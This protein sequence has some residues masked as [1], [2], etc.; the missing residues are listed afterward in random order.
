M[1]GC[2][3]ASGW[4]VPGHASL[5]TGRLAHDHGVHAF[6]PRYDALDPAE[7]LAGD[8]AGHTIGVS[9]N[10]YTRSDLGFDTLFDEF[11]GVT[12]D[13]PSQRGLD[14]HEAARGVEGVSR[15]PHLLKAALTHDSPGRSLANL[16]RVEAD[17]LVRDG[18][19]GREPAI[20]DDGARTAVQL[21]GSRVP[22]AEREAPVLAYVDL[23]EATGPMVDRRGL[24]RGTVPQGWSST[25]AGLTTESVVSDPDEFVQELAFYRHLYAENV[26][27]LDRLCGGLVEDLLRVTERET[28]VVVTASHGEDLLDDPTEPS[29][30]HVGSLSEAVLNVPLVLVNPPDGYPPVVEGPV[31]HLDLRSL[32]TGLAAGETPALGGGTVAAE[33]VGVPPGHET[34]V[35][36]DPERWDRVRRCLYPH[37]ESKVCWDDREMRVEYTLDPAQPC[38]QERVSAGSGGVPGWAETLFGES[39]A[40]IHDRTRRAV[41]AATADEIREVGPY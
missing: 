12:R 34:L 36:G 27:Y 15:Y 3:A 14:V 10:P 21:L 24:A 23:V 20:L 8:F 31:S 38:R 32:V 29:F 35:A 13:R 16:V 4:S 33:L 1:R 18:I 9:A 2:R 41:T 28:T 19:L 22:D 37:A 17:R 5:L 11:H 6:S 7:T 40:E 39:T 26:A 25:N 30:G